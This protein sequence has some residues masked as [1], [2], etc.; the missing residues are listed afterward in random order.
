MKFPP[1][2]YSTYLTSVSRLAPV[3]K[4]R[5]CLRRPRVA[6][7]GPSNAINSDREAA[8]P[9]ALFHGNPGAVQHAF[10]L[11]IRHPAIVTLHVRAA[12][13]SRLDLANLSLYRSIK[14][15]SGHL[16]CLFSTYIRAHKPLRCHHCYASDLL[17]HF[18]SYSFCGFFCLPCGFCSQPDREF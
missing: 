11:S 3:L 6:L 16:D 13:S 18:L 14:R 5:I 4:N 7:V 9:Q 1:A 17:F 10:V 2:S 15:Q 8:I 12:S